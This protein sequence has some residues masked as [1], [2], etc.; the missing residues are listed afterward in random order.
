[1]KKEEFESFANVWIEL[2]DISCSDKGDAGVIRV[3]SENKE[4]V[5][6]AAYDCE[7]YYVDFNLNGEPLYADWYESMVD[8]LR[9]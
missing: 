4:V 5:I 8:L 2:S 7:E 1:M 9:R 6:T 3:A